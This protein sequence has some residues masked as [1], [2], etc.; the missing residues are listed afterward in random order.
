MILA[1]GSVIQHARGPGFN[2]R[3]S[4]FIF[5]FLLPSICHGQCSAISCADGYC[6]GNTCCDRDLKTN[7]SRDNLFGL[8]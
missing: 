5:C 2:P 1:L 4:P 7:R 8:R 6:F 3:F